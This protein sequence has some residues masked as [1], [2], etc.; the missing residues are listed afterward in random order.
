MVPRPRTLF[1]TGLRKKKN[2]SALHYPPK[3]QDHFSTTKSNRPGVDRASFCT[4]EE[5][6]S[7]LQSK[8]KSPNKATTKEVTHKGSKSQIVTVNQGNKQNFVKKATWT[9]NMSTACVWNLNFIGMRSGMKTMG[10]QKSGWSTS[11]KTTRGFG[12]CVPKDL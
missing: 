8:L 12:K 11:W 1:R 6:F 9:A 5:A 2:Y 4:N 10:W 3:P 7:V